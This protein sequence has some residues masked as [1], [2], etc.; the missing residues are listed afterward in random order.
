MF[1]SIKDWATRPMNPVFLN[2]LERTYNASLRANSQ[3]KPHI[4]RADEYG[5]RCITQYG[6]QGTGGTPSEAFRHA[7][8][9]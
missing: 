4:F 6:S 7:L 3:G 1:C 5:Y 8:R 9:G 2:R